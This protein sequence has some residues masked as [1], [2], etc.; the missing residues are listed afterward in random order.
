MKNKI[1]LFRITN[2]LT[3]KEKA[4]MVLLA[5]DEEFKTGRCPITQ[6]E[7]DSLRTFGNTRELAEYHFYINLRGFGWDYINLTIEIC[8]LKN[9]IAYQMARGD[10]DTE[11]LN[12]T[13]SNYNFAHTL[14]KMADTLTEKFDCS[15]LGEFLGE[16][17]NQHLEFLETTKKVMNQRLYINFLTKNKSKQNNKKPNYIT[18]AKI[19]KKVIE[20]GI[21]LF[22][23]RFNDIYGK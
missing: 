18:E 23:N 20:Q 19:D 2:N 21:E 15:V 7:M 13:Q 4:K 17:I 6:D 11:L 14:K 12:A 10:I 3:T 16:K 1:N 22:T 9:L 8:L 5:L